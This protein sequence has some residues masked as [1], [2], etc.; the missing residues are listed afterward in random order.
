MG[1]IARQFAT[2][3]AEF[4]S[5]GQVLCLP[6]LWAEWLHR[7]RL[8]AN[9]GTTAYYN[10]INCEKFCSLVKQHGNPLWQYLQIYG[11][12][13][14]GEIDAP[15]GLTGKDFGRVCWERCT[16]AHYNYRQL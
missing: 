10:G 7:G 4:V 1:Y 8:T 5:P 2:F 15:Q 16:L 12:L 11:I 3:E 13:V 14:I 6:C 9:G